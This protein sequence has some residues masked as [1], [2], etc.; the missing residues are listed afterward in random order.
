M[1]WAST[2]DME[3]WAAPV[4]RKKLRG[5]LLTVQLT[6]HISDS[7]V[8]GISSVRETSGVLPLSQMGLWSRISSWK[9]SL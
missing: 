6:L 8:K 2:E 5:R 3:T 9:R 1:N 4:S 7:R